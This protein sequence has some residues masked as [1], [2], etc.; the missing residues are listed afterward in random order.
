MSRSQEKCW[1]L[2]VFQV[3]ANRNFPGLDTGCKNERSQGFWFLALTFERMELS[4]AEVEK[5]LGGAVLRGDFKGIFKFC[6]N[7]HAEI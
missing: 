4:T 3:E 2:C 5:P 6:L 1:L 7:I